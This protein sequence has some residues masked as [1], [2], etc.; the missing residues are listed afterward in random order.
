MIWNAKYETGNTQV[1]NEHKEIFRLVENVIE[2]TVGVDDAAHAAAFE[3]T[4][5]F[6]AKYTIDHFAHE[7]ALMMES[8]YSGF[9]VHKK[10]HDDFVVQ[11]V[12]LRERAA[13]NKSMKNNID[14]TNIIVNWL[15]D[16]VLGSDR[17]MAA[18]YREY[19]NQQ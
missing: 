3:S 4:F 9:D 11:V 12:A 5:D 14:I 8:S 19:K 6:L 18:H 17:I 1:D 2:T 10:Q 13:N 16:H 7:E 15:M